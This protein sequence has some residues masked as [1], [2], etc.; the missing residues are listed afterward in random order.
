MEHVKQ[1][2][3]IG[4]DA[5]P[6]S[7]EIPSPL[8][9]RGVWLPVDAALRPQAVA[10]I[11]AA[12]QR[13]LE[14][15]FGRMEVPRRFQ[16]LS[17]ATLTAGELAGKEAAIDAAERWLRRETDKPGLLVFGLPGVG[18]SALG[19]WAVPQRGWG[20]WQT[21]PELYK[22]VQEGYSRG[23]ARDKMRTAKDVPVLFLDD[24]GDPDRVW[25]DDKGKLRSRMATDDQR[26]ILFELINHR[27]QRW[28][29][30]FVTSNLTGEGLF[31]QFGDRIVS[32]LLELCEF[33]EMGGADLRR[34]RR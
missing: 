31:A 24:L 9:G 6:T 23:D 1:F 11:V 15:Q 27:C 7:G 2:I 21:W 29:P 14:R 10:N 18:K 3:V 28:T 17:P 26:D 33:V 22:T 4:N 12:R 8:D 25:R 16:G 34:L 19:W 30:V 5:P 32:R 13:K 20:L